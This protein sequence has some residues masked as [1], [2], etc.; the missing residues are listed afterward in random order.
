MDGPVA[1]IS[2]EGLKS[3]SLVAGESTMQVSSVDPDL[4][5]GD[6]V[7]N[8]LKEEVLEKGTKSTSEKA[9]PSTPSH[10]KPP[11]RTSPPKT[12][13]DVLKNMNL[14]PKDSISKR[15][16]VVSLDRRE[17]LS[18]GDLYQDDLENNSFR[19][20]SSSDTDGPTEMIRQSK[21]QKRDFRIQSQIDLPAHRRRRNVAEV[22]SSDSDELDMK[23]S[24]TSDEA[25]YFSGQLPSPKSA[26]R[27][28]YGNGISPFQ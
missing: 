22:A 28:G 6:N 25:S 18:V 19:S 23:S 15:N 20:S 12:S 13:P 24:D 8:S 9:N 27:K 4:S 17:V 1:A 14:K 10:E 16:R 2:P 7:A 21:Q 5:V 26:T 3:A 11:S